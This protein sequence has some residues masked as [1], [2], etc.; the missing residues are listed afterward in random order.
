MTTNLVGL[1]ADVGLAEHLLVILGGVDADVIGQ[2]LLG[3]VLACGVPLE[4]DLDLDSEHTLTEHDVTHGRVDVVHLGGSG[5]DH[6]AI[7]ELHGLSTL[8]AQLS[9]DDHLAALGAG[10]HDE[11]EHTVARAAHGEATDQLVTEGLGLGDGAQA[12]V[13]DL[14]G[15]QLN[16]P[17]RE[18]E[19]LLDDRGQLA[20][21]ATLLAENGLCAGSADDDLGT[22]RGNADLDT[23]VS[24]LSELTGEQLVQLGEEN[25][26][27]HELTLLADLGR[28]V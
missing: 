2:P 16:G 9:A 13:G 15:V 12:A 5:G 24:I 1:H 14:L 8:G 7:A 10:L 20:N 25:A 19:P 26:I 11:A 23:G 3:A 18:V 6:V 21:A 22:H 4:H 28:H 27:S 17:L